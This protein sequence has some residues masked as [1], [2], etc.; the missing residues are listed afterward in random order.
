MSDIQTKVKISIITICRNSTKTLKRTLNSVLDQSYDNFEYIVVDGAS[1]DNTVDIIKEYETPFKARNIPYSWLS[2]HDKGIYDAMNKAIE[3]TS[4]EIIGFVHS[5]DYYEPD[6]LETI[7]NA[8]KMQPAV[9]IFYGFLRQL[10]E[11][12]EL[13]V[14]RYNYNYYLKNTQTGVLSASQH[15]TCFV[16]RS[17]YNKIGKF[18]LQFKIAADYD[19]LLRARINNIVF[20]AL[21]KI[22]SNFSMEGASGNMSD[23]EIFEQRYRVLYKNGLLTDAEYKKQKNYLKYKRFKKVKHWV[24]RKLFNM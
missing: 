22:I 19:F 2:E 12:N 6:A 20:F 16:K 5:D 1:T 9:G 24:I 4:G 10:H 15:P 7:A 11:N 23:Y 17:V 8:N 21:D 3:M 14:Y 13:V 18:D